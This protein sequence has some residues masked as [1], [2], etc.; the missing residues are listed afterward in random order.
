MSN[1]SAVNRRAPIVDTRM[2]RTDAAIQRWIEV[3][4]GLAASTRAIRHGLAHALVGSGVGESQFSVLWICQQPAGDG[5]SQ[6][7]LADRLAISTAHISGLVEQMRRAGWL[8]GQRDPADRRRQVWRTTAAGQALFEQL[9]EDV[10]LWLDEHRE[11]LDQVDH[12][13]L[14]DL[15]ARLGGALTDNNPSAPPGHPSAS[16]TKR[17]SDQSASPIAPAVAPPRRKRGAA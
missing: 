11:A 4:E 16:A 9:V 6:S 10:A 3:L 17:S 8:D 5:I 2:P 7:E 13:R 12:E 15:V 14:S 1:H